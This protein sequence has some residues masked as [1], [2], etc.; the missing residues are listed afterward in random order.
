MTKGVRFT[1]EMKGFYTVGS[2]SFDAGFYNGRDAGTALLFHLTIG[3][4]DF[5]AHQAD[6]MHPCQAQGWVQC[7]SLGSGQLPVERGTFNLFAP[8]IS[9]GRMAMRYRL[10]FSGDDSQPY[11]LNGYKDVGNDPGFDLWPDTTTL[12]TRLLRGH[13]DEIDPDRADELGRGLLHLDAKMFARQLTTFRGDPATV[14]RFG[15][16][17]A[18]ALIKEYARRPKRSAHQ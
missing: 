16:E 12:Y 11:T 14:A 10:W 13:T 15:A 4:D 18:G 8:G 17:F 5:A 1:E 3:T 2:P 7:P 9:P 6:P